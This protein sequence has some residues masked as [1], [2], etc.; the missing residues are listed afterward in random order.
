MEKVVLDTNVLVSALWTTSGNPSAIVNLILTNRIIPCFDQDILNEYRVVLSRPRLS[1]PPGQV[2]ELLNELI[3]R[4]LSVTVLPSTTKLPDESDRKFYDVAN[5]CKAYLITGNTK[6]Y[7]KEPM[8][9]T[10]ASFL[11]I[12][13]R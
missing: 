9:R 12:I 5:F 3:N 10:P 8:I 13:K 6:H 11:E 7:P 2:D 4:G 1:F